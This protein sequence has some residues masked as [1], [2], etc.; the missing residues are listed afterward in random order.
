M[1]FNFASDAFRLRP[2]I[3]A[4]Y[5]ISGPQCLWS[6]A[7]TGQ[8]PPA[9]FVAAC[10]GEIPRCASRMNKENVDCVLWALAT[11]GLSLSPECMNALTSAAA[12]LAEV[13]GAF[14]FH[15]G[16]HTTASAW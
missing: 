13:L 14:Y 11:L 3:V 5:G 2:D 12:R 8:P 1:P 10:E 16:P 9:S 4:S 15:T 7:K 6:C